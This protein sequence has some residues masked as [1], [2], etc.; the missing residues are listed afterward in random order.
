MFGVYGWINGCVRF[1]AA[2]MVV[3]EVCGWI[4][5]C[6]GIF[7]AELMVVLGGLLLDI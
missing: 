1:M 4:Y 7:V 5:G 6:V 3:Q 2:L